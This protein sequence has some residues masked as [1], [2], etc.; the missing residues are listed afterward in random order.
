MID[1]VFGALEHKYNFYKYEVVKLFDQEY[2]VK[3]VVESYDDTITDLQKEN[4]LNYLDYLASNKSAVEEL[5]KQYFRDV[6]GKD[7]DIQENLTPTTIY[8]S[9]DGSW[10]ILFDTNLDEENGFAL[11]VVDN[12][13]QVG[14]QDMFI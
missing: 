7:I 8:F 1:S 6:Y 5:I 2:K 9:K 12:Q 14:T 11:F 4:Y 13:L 10:G 3:I